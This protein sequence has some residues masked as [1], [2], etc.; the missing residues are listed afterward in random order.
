[1]R[2]YS[3]SLVFCKKFCGI[4]FNSSSNV[5]L[6]L[7]VKLS[8]PGGIFSKGFQIRNSVGYWAAQS[9]FILD[10]LWLFVLSEELV[11]SSELSSLRYKLFVIFPY[12]FGVCR[13]CN[14]SCSIPNVSNL[15]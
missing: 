13:V 1:M 7:L 12:S 4:C 8:G 5:W 3:S 2:R 15:I 10:E 14:I 6:T 9:Y 11:I